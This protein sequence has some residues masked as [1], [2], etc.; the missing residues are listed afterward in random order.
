M[1][2]KKID[3]L[4]FEE[5][6]LNFENKHIENIFK[7]YAKPLNQ[8]LLKKRYSKCYDLIKNKY[9]PYLKDKTGEFLFKLKENKNPDYKIF[10]NK[11]GDYKFS[12]FKLTDKSI[13]SKKGLYAYF[14]EDNLMYLGRC[15]DTFYR[16][17]NY[18]Y[19][20]ISP[21]NCYLDGQ[22]TNCHLN[23]LITKKADKIKLFIY[24]MLNDEEIK[25]KERNLIKKFRPKWNI[26]LNTT[27]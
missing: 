18:G 8:L 20:I 17:L 6:H 16:R 3:D 23:S 24:I 14:L 1:N 11:Y 7:K 21:K 27:L 25:E 19:G 22:A 15:T 4:I 9:Q 12:T 2:S 5:Y 26:A 10:L 13:F